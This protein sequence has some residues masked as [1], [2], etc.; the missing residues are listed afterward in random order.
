MYYNISYEIAGV[1][2]LLGLI[3]GRR[4]Y[5]KSEDR[6]LRMFVGVLMLTLATSISNI[7]AALAYSEIIPLSN[8]WMLVTESVYLL[9]AV[10]SCYFMLRM[11]S[12]RTGFDAEGFRIG[13]FILIAAFSILVMINVGTKFMFWYEYHDGR[14]FVGTKWFHLDY[15]VYVLLF[16]EI[17]FVL[18]RNGRKLR[19]RVFV[20]T[21]TVF[22]F[23]VVCIFIQFID[24]RIL[25]SGIG[26]IGA[27][28]VYSFTLG[29]E[30]FESLQ[31][32]LEQ[33]KETEVKEKE[34]REEIEKVQR[35]KDMFL[36]DISERFD[37]PLEE[38]LRVGEEM[39]EYQ[40]NPEI[41][42]YIR[43]INQAGNQLQEFV[44][45]LK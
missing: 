9:L 43:Q 7:F 12:E 17:A 37:T 35:V 31:N 5:F 2:I 34:N 27:L 6:T 11:V 10:Y 40:D 22:F 36:Q 26:A 25:L 4:R 20:L 42:E 16:I 33:L 1:V 21:S 15:L 30:D 39:K 44:G 8:R 28:L 3:L 38:V 23:P 41:V 32:T 13:N 29:E 18:I 24:D 19:R 45:E 14:E